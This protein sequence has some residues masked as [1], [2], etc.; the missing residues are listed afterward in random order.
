ML[1]GDALGT[2]KN[3]AKS[4]RLLNKKMLSCE[5]RNKDP[6]VINKFFQDVEDSLERC[7]KEDRKQCILIEGDPLKIIFGKKN[8]AMGK[9][10][11]KLAM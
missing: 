9:R 7:E 4:C 2:A 1:T 6:D 3:I 5:C 10:F 11:L 8:S